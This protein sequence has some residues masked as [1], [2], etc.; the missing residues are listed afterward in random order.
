MIVKEEMFIL[1]R[2][3]THHTNST[4]TVIDATENITWIVGTRDEFTA[5][6][7]FTYAR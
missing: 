2:S 7:T 4:G 6:A 3:S 1:H 5:F